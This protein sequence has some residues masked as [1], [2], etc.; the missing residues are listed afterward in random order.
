MRLLFVALLLAA[1][2]AFAQYGP[3][4]PQT[5]SGPGYNVSFQALAK[6]SNLAASTSS[7]TIALAIKANQVQIFNSTTGV[8]FVIFCTASSCTASA[9]STGTSTSDYPVAAGA[10]VVVTVPA[11]TTY[12]AAIL[13]TSTGAV[14]F[15]PGIG[16]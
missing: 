7:A 14:Y 8:A 2:P 6:T 9:G 13:S 3:P 5:D 1:L 15:T 10:V 4:S 12:A 16:L 11:G